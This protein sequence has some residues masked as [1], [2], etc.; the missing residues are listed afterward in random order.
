MK[1][2]SHSCDYFGNLGLICGESTILIP[3]G[4][5]SGCFD[6]YIYETKEEVFEFVIKMAD[7]AEYITSCDFKN[8]KIIKYDCISDIDKATSHIVYNLTGLTS[9]YTINGNIHLVIDD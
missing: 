2:L 9:I 8:V 3:N 1:K 7:K 5:G 4:T 6:I